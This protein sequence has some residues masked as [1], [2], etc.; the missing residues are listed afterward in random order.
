MDKEIAQVKH[1]LSQQMVLQTQRNAETVHMVQDEGSK[2]TRLDKTYHAFRRDLHK[3]SN[4]L[5]E[6]KQKTGQQR[7]TTFEN[8]RLITNM[9]HKIRMSEAKLTAGIP[10]QIT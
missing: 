2:I 3:Y 6:L 10:F 1:H 8:A 9:E 7:L 5:E 4:D